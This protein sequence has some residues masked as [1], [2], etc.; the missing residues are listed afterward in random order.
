MSSVVSDLSFAKKFDL[1]YSSRF[2][3]ISLS[4]SSLDS[5]INVH[6]FVKLVASFFE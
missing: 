5:F 3:F 2:F 6:F 1:D 4:L